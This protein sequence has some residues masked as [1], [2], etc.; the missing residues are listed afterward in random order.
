MSIADKQA[1]YILFSFGID[2]QW[3]KHRKL[4][5]YLLS[6]ADELQKDFLDP[7]TFPYL[8]GFHTTPAEM[9]Q[10]HLAR[11]DIEFNNFLGKN[12]SLLHPSANYYDLEDY[13]GLVHVLPSSTILVHADGQLSFAGD[14]TNMKDLVPVLEEF[15]YTMDPTLR[16]QVL[17]PNFRW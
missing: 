13:Y 15:R 17:V 9:H 11:T 10:L 12:A 8:V 3:R 14:M 7:F 16:K 1:D 4:M 5:Q 6:G 2:E